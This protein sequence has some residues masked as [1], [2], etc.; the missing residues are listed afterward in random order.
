MTATRTRQRLVTQARRLPGGPKL[1]DLY[2]SS[3]RRVEET[4]RWR[5]DRQAGK[6][7]EDLAAGDAIRMAYNVLLD[8]EPDQL[9]IDTF[10]GWLAAG[11]SKGDMARFIRSSDEFASYNAFREMGPSV[12]YGRGV[13]VR[14]LPRARRILDLGGSSRNSVVG[15]LVLFDYPYAFDELVIVELPSD[16]RH[17]H[18][19]DVKEGDTVPTHLGPVRYHYH[20]MTDLSAYENG[21][22]DL[23]YSGQTIE[24]V[25]EADADKVLEEVR[26]VLRPGGWFAF[27]T[28][29]G[30]VCRLQQAEFIDPDHK[31]EYTH[32]QVLE[33]LGRAGFEVVRQHGLNYAGRSVAERRFDLPETARRWGLYDDAEACYILAYVCRSPGGA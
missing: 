30:A 9:G 14:S 33:K 23:V 10:R 31:V 16:Q 5:A 27:D 21:S 12:H 1:I 24:H 7:F 25:E 4:L 8:R 6:G 18:Y 11:K 15:A 28:P 32:A 26:R 22:F 29:N 19:L 2:R 17:E 20:S 13:F 3:R